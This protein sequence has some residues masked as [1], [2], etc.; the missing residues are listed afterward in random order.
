MEPGRISVVLVTHESIAVLDDCLGH[1]I[2]ELRS[3]GAELIVVDN[4]SRDGSGPRVA[5]LWP[6][7]A[8]I[9]NSRNRGFAAA[10]N[11]GAAAASGEWLVLL[12]PDVNVDAGALGELRA[13]L[14]AN[15][16][17]G[18]VAGRLRSPDGRFQASCRRFP[19][20][21][22]L[23]QSRGSVL[24]RWRRTGVPYT[25]PDANHVVSVPAVACAF[26][27]IRRA[28]FQSLG[29]FDERFFLFMEDTDLSLRLERAGYRNLFVPEAGATHRWGQGA[30][31]GKWRRTLHHHHSMWKYFRKHDPGGYSRLVLPLLLTGNLLARS[32]L[33]P[34]RGNPF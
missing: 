29:G 14:L 27:M 2:P 4:D 31:S 15:S 8:L 12:N 9:R 33:R 5:A 16:D 1:V 6:P 25:L 10:C 26:V 22:N 11:Q 24:S 30:R 21:G 3:N 17:A 7:A 34:R 20:A 28:L 23:I 19:T 13:T 18:F 32:L